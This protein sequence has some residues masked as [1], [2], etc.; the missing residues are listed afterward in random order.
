MT[1]TKKGESI[2]FAVSSSLSLLPHVFSAKRF[3]FFFVYVFLFFITIKKLEKE[4]Q[5]NAGLSLNT[6]AR[7]LASKSTFCSIT[8]DQHGG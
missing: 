7:R 4:R 6:L 5:Q 1:T 3:F 8:K 2:N